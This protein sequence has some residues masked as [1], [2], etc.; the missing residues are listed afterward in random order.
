MCTIRKPKFCIKNWNLINENFL[1][2]SYGK[3][4]SVN[5][6]GQILCEEKE[7]LSG[8]NQ[9]FTA[10]LVVF[11]E[12]VVDHDQARQELTSHLIRQVLQSPKTIID[13]GVILGSMARLVILIRFS[14][15][16]H[17]DMLDAPV[18]S[19]SAQALA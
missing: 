18:A 8:W 5:K 19:D 14:C 4:P 1:A 13:S 2:L 10:D 17:R 16:G 6:L 9:K 12:E 3:T 15:L 7:L 11:Q